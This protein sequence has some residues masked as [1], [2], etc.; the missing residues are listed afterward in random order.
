MPMGSAFH[1]DSE[2]TYKLDVSGAIVGGKLQMSIQY[3][4]RDD[5]GIAEELPRPPVPDYR[6]L[7]TKRGC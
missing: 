6:A 5:Q 2:R 3:P 1:R 4:G 7:R